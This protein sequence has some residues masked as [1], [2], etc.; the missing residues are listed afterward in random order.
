MK[1]PIKLVKNSL[2]IIFFD[3]SVYKKSAI[4]DISEIR[5]V[6]SM[7]IGFFNKG[8]KFSSLKISNFSNQP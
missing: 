7:F 8:E 4:S 6:V 2:Q 1:N 3:T 5:Y